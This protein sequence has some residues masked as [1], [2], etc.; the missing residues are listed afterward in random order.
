MSATPEA[1]WHNTRPAPA[2]S[3]GLS[4]NPFWVLGATTRD[5]RRRIVE[6]CDALA[7]ELGGDDAQKAR[8]ALTNP[9]ARLSQEV[10]WLPGVAPKKAWQYVTAVE[11]QGLALANDAGISPLARSNL[12]AAAF[13]C[14]EDLSP[15]AFAASSI[16]LANLLEE[17]DPSLVMREINEDREVAGFPMIADIADIEFEIG[18]RR[19][20]CKASVKGALDR[21]ESEHLIEAML[22]MV[23]RSTRDGKEAAPAL[24]EDLVDAYALEV[25]P[26]LTARADRIEEE[27]QHVLSGDP[28]TAASA[29]ITL[30]CPGARR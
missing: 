1:E 5:D 23:R 7:L 8:A 3:H 2:A 26:I 20:V 28:R 21:M 22:T 19:A 27:I 6:L 18:E 16:G 10:A 11:E 13:D 25:Q 15:A 4:R 9:R 30:A 24:V 12:T 17:I 29:A 14:A